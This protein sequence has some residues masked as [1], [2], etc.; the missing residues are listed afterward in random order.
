MFTLGIIIASD[1]GSKGERAD[2]S[3]IVIQQMME[4]NGYITKKYIILPDEADALSQEMIFM[5]DELGVDLILTSGGTG[6]S[7]RDITP[8]A[9]LQVVHRLTPGISEAIRYN[10]LQIT[11]R[12]MLSR[13]ISG[14][15]NNT[16]IINLPGS[17][18]A[19]R[20]SLEYIL[21]SLAHGLEILKGS[22]SECA[23]K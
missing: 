22:A 16:L 23:R 7:K 10:S 19:V 17:P 20:E 8:E 18:K 15:R 1:K 12:A 13:A 6:F 11:P 4:T 3:G 14:I 5:S 9:T 2:E 21:P